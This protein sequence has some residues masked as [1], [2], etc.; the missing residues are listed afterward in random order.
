MD[1]WLIFQ[2]LVVFVMTWGGTVLDNR[3]V[4]VKVTSKR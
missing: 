4:A 3:C 2:S 1:Y